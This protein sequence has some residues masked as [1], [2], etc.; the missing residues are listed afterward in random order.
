MSPLP[1]L[2]LRHK[3]LNFGSMGIRVL[4]VDNV[5]QSSVDI[6]LHGQDLYQVG[7]LDELLIKSSNQFIGCFSLLRTHSR[8]LGRRWHFSWSPYWWVWSTLLFQ[9]W[10]LDLVI[11]ILIFSGL[12]HFLLLVSVNPS[13]F[14]HRTAI[15]ILKWS[16]RNGPLIKCPVLLTPL[17]RHWRPAANTVP[18]E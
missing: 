6:A 1:Q 8:S 15:W 14:P 13:P 17:R 9:T 16:F 2:V 10:K 12:F 11:N 18:T 4:L 7:A 5:V 3:L